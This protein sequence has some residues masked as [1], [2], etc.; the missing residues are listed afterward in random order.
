MSASII[1]KEKSKL[2]YL[3]ESL[4][5]SQRDQRDR[6]GPDIDQHSNS[7][8]QLE[9]LPTNE[10][11]VKVMNKNNTAIVKRSESRATTKRKVR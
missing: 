4:A 8:H 9:L 2:A 7:V 6:T 1:N 3:L 11:Y 10:W 5:L